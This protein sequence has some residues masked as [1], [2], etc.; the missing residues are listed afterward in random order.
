MMVVFGYISCFNSRK[1][2]F[3]FV[4]YQ[5]KFDELMNIKCLTS[6]DFSHCSCNGH[7]G[8]KDGSNH[9]KV[10]ANFEHLIS[11]WRVIFKC[12]IYESNK[13]YGHRLL[14]M[15]QC[16]MHTRGLRTADINKNLLGH[17]SRISFFGWTVWVTNR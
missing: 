12:V 16:S 15:V 8:R 2:F 4:Q 1:I 5:A 9:S 10:W 14:R 17:V 7:N 6:S 3:H 11:R 13:I